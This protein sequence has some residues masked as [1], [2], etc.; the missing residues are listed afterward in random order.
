M[1][2]LGEGRDGGGVCVVSLVKLQPCYRKGYD[3]STALF[4]PL[5]PKGWSGTSAIF[6]SR[7]RPDAKYKMWRPRKRRGLVVGR[8]LGRPHSGK[9]SFLADP[10]RLR[11]SM[12]QAYR[13]VKGGTL[14]ILATRTTASLV[15]AALSP[16]MG[17]CLV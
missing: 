2:V 3:R 10:G 7:L 8:Y 9:L 17:S 11:P 4:E 13:E 14:K 15:S 1:A 5:T 6:L 16:S 12:V